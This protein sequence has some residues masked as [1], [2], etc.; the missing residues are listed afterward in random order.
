M[1]ISIPKFLIESQTSVNRFLITSPPSPRAAPARLDVFHPNTRYDKFALR[2][3][4]F[5]SLRPRVAEVQK[6]FLLE[7][8]KKFSSRF[9]SSIHVLITTAL[10]TPAMAVVINA[11]PVDLAANLAAV[12]ADCVA[13]LVNR[14]KTSTFRCVVFKEESLLMLA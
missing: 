13:A 6:I 11:I 7:Y 5:S 10:P 14:I 1:Q 12:S 2:L 9:L 3:P 8:C 4:K